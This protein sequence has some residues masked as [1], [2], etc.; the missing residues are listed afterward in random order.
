[1]PT[2]TWDE[3][4]TPID[5]YGGLSDEANIYLANMMN[6]ANYYTP[7]STST[8][9]KANLPQ[10]NRQ[11]YENNPELYYNTVLPNET[12]FNPNQRSYFESYYPNIYN[13]YQV[14]RV[15]KY[16]SESFPDW[17]ANYDY[18]GE[19]NKLTDPQRGYNKQRYAPSSIWR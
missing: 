3:F 13:Q 18:M 7:A 2:P 17:L 11:I 5:K 14:E 19:W 16:P 10:E 8:R 15:S 12:G 1:M 4:W 9:K 6:P